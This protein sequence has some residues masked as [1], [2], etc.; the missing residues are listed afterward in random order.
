V[1]MNF[2]VD[3]KTICAI[4]VMNAAGVIPAERHMTRAKDD[5]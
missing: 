4:I 1:Y 5:G 2:V 3:M